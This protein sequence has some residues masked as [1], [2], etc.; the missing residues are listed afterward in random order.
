MLILDILSVPV[1]EMRSLSDNSVESLTH[2]QA[3][4]LDVIYSSVI[5][6][7]RNMLEQKD[8]LRIIKTAMNMNLPTSH[9][10]YSNHSLLI[11]SLNE[12]I[13]HRN[14]NQNLPIPERIGE[15]IFVNDLSHNEI[16]KA[17]DMLQILNQEVI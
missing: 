5:S 12:T 14:G 9:P 10:Y 2:G 7:Q 17:A 16:K 3:V 8:V 11:E 1:I 13:K 6:M 4:T 15:S